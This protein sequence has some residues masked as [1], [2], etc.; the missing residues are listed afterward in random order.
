LN[1]RTIVFWCHLAVGAL[2]ASVVILMCVTGVL[3][4]YQKQMQH[5]ADTR[6]L[7]GAAPSS[8]ARRLSADS[9]LARAQAAIHIAPT[10]ILVRADADA[11]VEITLGRERKVFLNAYTG[12]VLGDGSS[13][14]RGF[15]RAVTSW[16]RT[17]GATGERRP[18]GRS[19]TGAA[20]L[21]FFFI[22]LSG[23]FLWWPRTWTRARLRNIAL[24][25]RR[26]SGKARDFNW[27]NTIGVWSF[28][29]LLAIVASGVVM[30]YPWANALVYRIAGEEPPRQQSPRAP[31][32]H[33]G[34]RERTADRRTSTQTRAAPAVSAMPALSVDAA[35]AMGAAKMPNWRS[36][37]MQLPSA[38]A[39]TLTVSLDGGTGGQP[40]KR[41][42]LVLDRPTGAVSRWEPFSSQT[43]GRRLRS[44]LR[45][46]HTGEV[47]GLIGQTIAGMVSL[48][49]VIL[50]WTGVALALRRF[51]TWRRRSARAGHAQ[52]GVQGSEARHGRLIGRERQRRITAAGTS[53]PRRHAAR[54]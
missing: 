10:A 27:H 49:A 22:L 2:V 34:P 24:F 50:G 8:G 40:Q 39:K 5:W 36:I 53:T 9:L 30:S 3:L 15:F 32:Q 52:R 13:A 11:P 41:G 29:P 42:S 31:A 25:R 7:V 54:R 18:L 38:S 35:L 48:G 47:L 6:G 21:G 45:F 37:S 17:I 26:S 20:N 1:L 12:A 51:A 46:V 43:P 4:T 28:L 14:M 16:H 23:L 44:I 33:G 19:F